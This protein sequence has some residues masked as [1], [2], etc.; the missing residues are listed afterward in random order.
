ME[1]NSQGRFISAP[2]TNEE[3][4]MLGVK[5]QTVYVSTCGT[6]HILRTRQDYEKFS[7]PLPDWFEDFS[8]QHE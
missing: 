6:Q 1:K 4:K 7:L 3:L 8:E 5:R 2:L